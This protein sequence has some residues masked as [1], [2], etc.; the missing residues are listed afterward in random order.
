MTWEKFRFFFNFYKFFF[1][2][3]QILINLQEI[4]NMQN[5]LQN[6]KCEV[7]D[8][9]KILQSDPFLMSQN[10]EIQGY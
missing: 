8:S 9:A 5:F 7:R 3:I 2:N 10:F 1:L 4:A 6:K